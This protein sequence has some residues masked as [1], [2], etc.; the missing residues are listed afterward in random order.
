MPLLAAAGVTLALNPRASG[1]VGW[2]LSF[3]AVV[4]IYLLAGPI[5]GAIVSRRGSGPWGRALA[6]GIAVT[7][8]A[9]LATAPLI[10]LHFGTVQVGSL[11]ANLLALPAVAPAM[12]LGMIAAAL[13]QVPG[14]PVELINSVNALLLGYVAQIAA[15]F[16]RPGWAEVEVGLSGAPALLGAYAGIAVA[17]AAVLRAAVGWRQPPRRPP[18]PFSA[19][20][21]A[22]HRGGRGSGR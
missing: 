9:T 11:F 21:R 19:A 20:G 3:A 5:R 14:F 18:A 8:A 7:A 16:G 22:A 15:W 12:W 10:A 13:G 2:Q 17:V 1:D 6:E 4:G